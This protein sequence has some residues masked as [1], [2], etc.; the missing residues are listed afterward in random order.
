MS[1]ILS[2]QIRVAFLFNRL[3]FC[4]NGSMSR[5][6]DNEIMGDEE[7]CIRPQYLRE[8]ISQDKVKSS[9]IF[10]KQQKC[11]MRRWT[12]FFVWP[13]GQESN[14]SFVI[15]MVGSISNKRQVLLSTGD[16]GSD[17]ERLGARMC[18]LSTRFINLPMSVEEVPLQCYGRFHR[19]HDW[20][21]KL[22]IVSI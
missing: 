7:L 22:A 5:I 14:H 6:L 20:C 18:S 9:K 12:M 17:F 13:S 11:V 21:R 16:L 10:I 2:H 1:L 19:H 15:V 4:Y 3:D 8:Y